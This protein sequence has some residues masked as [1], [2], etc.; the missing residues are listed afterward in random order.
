[1]SE[2]NLHMLL[3]SEGGH[4]FN[5]VVILIQRGNQNGGPENLRTD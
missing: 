4:V 5:A 1:V 2:M 3:V